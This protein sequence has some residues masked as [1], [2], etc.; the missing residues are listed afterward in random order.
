MRCLGGTT[1]NC[2]PS[3]QVKHD[4]FVRG[5]VGGCSNTSSAFIVVFWGQKFCMDQ[6]FLIEKCNKHC[7]HLRLRHPGFLRPCFTL[8]NPLHTLMLSLSR[9]RKAT[10]HCELSHVREC[11]LTQLLQANH[12][13]HQLDVSSIPR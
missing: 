7:F 11:F 4:K 12:G 8:T 6:D 13:K 1:R 3:S 2:L 9:T 5:D 10:A